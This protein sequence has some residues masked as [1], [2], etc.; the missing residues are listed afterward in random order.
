[1]QKK[2]QQQKQVRPEER[3]WNESRTLQ[4]RQMGECKQFEGEIEID[5]PFHVMY[6]CVCV[7]CIELNWRFGATNANAILNVW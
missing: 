5:I 4:L 6:V 2:H 1:M 7:V 3:W